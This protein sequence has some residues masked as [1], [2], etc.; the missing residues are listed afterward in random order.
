MW[1]Y[2]TKPNAVS[3]LRLRVLGSSLIAGGLATQESDLEEE[4]LWS[5]Q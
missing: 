3:L 1:H 5:D 2:S 4:F